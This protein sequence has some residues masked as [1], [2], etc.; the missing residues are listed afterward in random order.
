[1]MITPTMEEVELAASKIGL[2]SIEAQKFWYFYDSKGWRVG[3]HKMVSF[4]SALSHWKLNWIERTKPQTPN[5]KR[6]W[7][8]R[9]VEAI[10]ELVDREDGLL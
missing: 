8:E 2:P 7:A 3:K 4:N 10:G 5:G 6:H 1:M 9:E